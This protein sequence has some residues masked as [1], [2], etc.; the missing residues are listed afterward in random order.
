MSQKIFQEFWLKLEPKKVDVTENTFLPTAKYFKPYI[1]LW[2]GK[3]ESPLSDFLRSIEKI[4]VDDQFLFDANSHLEEYRL[5][6]ELKSSI[7]SQVTVYNNK[8]KQFVSWFSHF[9]ENCNKIGFRETSFVRANGRVDS[10]TQPEAEEWNVATLLEYLSLKDRTPLEI[11]SIGWQYSLENSLAESE[12]A[13][14]QQLFR[15]ANSKDISKITRLAHTIDE[16]VSDY[17]GRSTDLS[18]DE[19]KIRYALD[20]FKERIK[21]LVNDIEEETLKGTCNYEKKI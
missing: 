18:S 1:S 21:Y 5:T 13:T 17:E 10:R 3:S 16:I 14:I 9:V 19:G 6:K 20:E 11:K 8:A 2:F 7:E 12:T 15:I 4:R